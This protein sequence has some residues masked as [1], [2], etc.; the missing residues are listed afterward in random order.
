[1]ISMVEENNLEPH[2]PSEGAGTGPD[3]LGAGAPESEPPV[4][5]PAADAKVTTASGGKGA[6]T[7][8]QRLALKRDKKS[9]QKQ[10]LKADIQRQKD[11]EQAK[12]QEEAERFLGIQREPSTPDP[13]A[14]TAT[15]VTSYF[16]DNRGWIVG[17]VVGVVALGFAIVLSRSYLFTGSS[18]Q[19]NLL[20]KAVQ[21]ANAPIDEN[22]TEGKDADGKPVFKNTGDRAAKA[23]D[24]Y[25]AAAKHDA[26]SLAGSWAKLGQGSV[27]LSAGKVSE[28]QTLFSAIFGATKDKP[29]IAAQALEGS[30]I[31]LEATG[32]VDEALKRFEELKGF[33]SGTYKDLAEYHVARIKLSRGDREGAKTLLKTLYDR[34]NSPPEGAPKSRYLKGE[35]EVR[36]AELDSSLVPAGSGE[37]QQ[38]SPEEIQRLIQQMQMQQ[39]QK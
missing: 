7:P 4:N 36:L 29:V 39:Q 5:A 15:Q 1:M 2:A 25:A 14:Q 13:V 17:S 22:N 16:Q 24:A 32:K 18:E 28:A 37:G 38:F 20:A 30:A 34:L 27:M 3:E 9:Q 10:E 8:G 23:A 21:T 31:A 26:D 35:V 12:E 11:D 6:L 33:D 19:A